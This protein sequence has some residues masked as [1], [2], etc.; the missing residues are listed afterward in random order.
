MVDDQ[1]MRHVFN[2][3]HACY[4]PKP[5]RGEMALPNARNVIPNIGTALL[6]FIFPLR[7]SRSV[8]AYLCDHEMDGKFKRRLI[9]RWH[10]DRILQAS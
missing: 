6:P 7:A 1:P 10:I 9:Q 4:F 3:D 2:G 5:W 8:R